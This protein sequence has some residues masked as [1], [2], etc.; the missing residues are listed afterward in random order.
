[1]TLL[2]QGYSPPRPHKPYSEDTGHDPCG[3]PY[4]RLD[5]WCKWRGPIC[6]TAEAAVEAWREHADQE[7]RQ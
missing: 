6:T 3:G 4:F 5:C 2:A 7:G 1:M